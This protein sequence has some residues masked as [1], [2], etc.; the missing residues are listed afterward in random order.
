[1][2]LQIE[3]RRFDAD[4]RHPK[5]RE[6]L[7]QGLRSIVR[8]SWHLKADS[9]GFNIQIINSFYFRLLIKRQNYDVGE[10]ALPN[11]MHELNNMIEKNWL[12]LNLESYKVKC[13][14]LFLK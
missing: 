2:L 3:R 7:V 11:R 12:N 14:D 4:E 6:D 1:M 13:K 8:Q 10:N 9:D 5:V